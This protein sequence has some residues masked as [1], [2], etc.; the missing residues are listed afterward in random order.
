MQLRPA[1]CS[2]PRATSGATARWSPSRATRCSPATSPAWAA[3]RS[4][5]TATGPSTRSS[6]ELA[7]P[8]FK[9]LDITAQGRYDDYND[10]G[11]KFTYKGSLRWQPAKQ[12]LVR[13]SYGT[14]FR[15]PTLPDLWSPQVLGTLGAV[16][17]PGV[18]E[19]SQSSGA[20]DLRRQSGAR[21]GNLEAVADRRRLV[22]DARASASAP[23]IS[24]SSSSNII[25]TPS[26]QEV[27]SQ[28]RL[29]DPVVPEPGRSSRRARTTSTRSAPSSTTPA[30]RR[31]PAGISKPSGARSSRSATS[32]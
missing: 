1:R 4:R 9:S 30:A 26:A 23:S 3:P 31:S 32:T 11:S 19:Q 10:V 25:T 18:P 22:A 5:S 28:Y 13:A 27:V 12:Y 14:G 17:R 20:R 15:P 16:H 7:I 21:A 8:I 29:G 2:T 6:A 24:T